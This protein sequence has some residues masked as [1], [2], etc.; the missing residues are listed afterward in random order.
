MNRIKGH[1]RICTQC[2]EER[3]FQ[4]NNAVCVKCWRLN[5]W[6]K[7]G[8]VR[9]PEYPDTTVARFKEPMEPVENGHGFIGAITETTDGEHIQC[10][11]CGYFYAKLSAH[12]RSHGI[13][14]RDYK[15]KFGLRIRAGLQ[16]PK[17]LQRAQDTYN[18]FARVL[19]R[20]RQRGT[21]AAKKRRKEKGEW[22]K[23]GDTWLP[24]LRNERGNCKEQTLARIRS[25]AAS[26]GGV[27]R[28][29]DYEK[30]YGNTGTVKYWF[31]SWSKAVAAAG[32]QTNNERL[33]VTRQAFV[34]GALESMSNFFEQH[35]RTP[36]TADFKANETLPSYQYLTRNFGSLNNARQAAGIPRLIRKGRHFTEQM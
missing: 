14:S 26:N 31:G 5:K 22:A 30:E 7:E 19:E 13:S 35:G 21:A 3:E 1:K 34:S 29:N 18:N 28:Y 15:I 10:H 32:L 23:G 33:A 16:A 17:E 6:I 27:A 2:K 25:L 12:V 4:S 11:I 24:Q 9:P 36:Q 8:K 20:A